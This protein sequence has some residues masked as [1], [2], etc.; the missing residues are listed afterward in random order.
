M[1]AR[2]P[3]C[4]VLLDYSKDKTHYM[5]I[6]YDIIIDKLSTADGGGYLAYYKNI[7]SIMGDVGKSDEK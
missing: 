7:P 2:K 5:N 3:N 4:Q 6:D 1:D